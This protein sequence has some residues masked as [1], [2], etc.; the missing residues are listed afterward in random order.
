MNNAECQIAGCD[1]FDDEAERDKVVNAI[2]VL[3][4]FCE[5]FVKRVD[6]FDA[7][8]AAV[9]DVFF[10]ERVFDGV[11]GVLELFV[12]LLEA[13]FGEILEEL[14]AARVEVAE[15]GFFDFDADVTHLE[16]VGERREDFERFA[17]D[18]FLFFRR[19][20]TECAQV[21]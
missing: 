18:F 12:G 13:L 3:V 21:V 1:V 17:R 19:K 16:A 2:D 11:L 10:F 14:E 15:A 7:A 6:R 4:V 9:R 5:L 8:V 20:C